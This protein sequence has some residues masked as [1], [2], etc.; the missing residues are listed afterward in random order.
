MAAVEKVFQGG[1]SEKDKM[2]KKTASKLGQ[3]RE[4]ASTQKGK[5]RGGGKRMGGRKRGGDEISA[6]KH[7]K[8]RRRWINYM[9]LKFNVHGE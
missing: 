5:N 7:G 9:D 8:G 4:M 2:E 6:V 1:R 3:E